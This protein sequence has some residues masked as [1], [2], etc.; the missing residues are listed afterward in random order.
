MDNPQVSNSSVLS[1]DWNRKQ[2]GEILK[3]VSEVWQKI[4]MREHVDHSSVKILKGE[5]SKWKRVGLYV[6]FWAE[7]KADLNHRYCV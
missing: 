4:S 6:S 7:H 2:V 3:V 5:N 1:M